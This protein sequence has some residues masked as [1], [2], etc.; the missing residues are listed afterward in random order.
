MLECVHI[1]MN[2]CAWTCVSA[3]VCMNPLPVARVAELPGCSNINLVDGGGTICVALK[4]KIL[5]SFQFCSF[6]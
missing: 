1:D 4:K 6:E 3:C 2:V 5:F